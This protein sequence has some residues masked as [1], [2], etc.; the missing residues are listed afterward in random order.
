MVASTEA[1]A[2]LAVL[3]VD[4][5]ATLA[6]AFTRVLSDTGHEVVHVTTGEAALAAVR[7]GA[8]HVALVDLVLPGLAGAPLLA[9]LRAV[10]AD[11]GIVV[12]TGY[13]SLDTAV[14]AI[15]VHVDAYLTKP[16]ASADL[17]ATV[18]T[19]GRRRGVIMHDVARL[20]AV[21]GRAVNARRLAHGLTLKQ[22]ARRTGLSISLLSGI[23]RARSAGSVGALLRLATALDCRIADFLDGL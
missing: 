8:F 1:T 10:D 21:I 22:L 19:V 2:R 23:E 11:L 3:I 12:V 16:I 6:A 18:A 14:A 5:D 9:E 13:P 4:D 20:Q 17:V 15:G 7:P